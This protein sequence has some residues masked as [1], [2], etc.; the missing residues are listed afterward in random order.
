MDRAAKRELVTSLNTVFKDTGVIVVA[1][2]AGLVASQSADFRRRVKAA[3]GTVKVAK[4]RLAA[5]A[6]EGTDA[7]GI[8]GLLKGPTILAYSSD[9]ISAAKI[10]VAYAKENEKL[11]ILGGA[12]GKTVLDAN[13]VKALAELPSLDE[14]RAKLLGLIKEPAS[15]LARTINEPGSALARLLKARVDKQGEAA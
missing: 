3:G 5:L 11:V 1:R 4:N 15:K 8:K 9:P 13:G 6:L 14:L 2:N 10:A 12:M 7:A